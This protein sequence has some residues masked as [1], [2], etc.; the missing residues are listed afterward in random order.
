MTEYYLEA[1]VMLSGWALIEADS[2]D[3][4]RRKF[5]K[6]PVNEFNEYGERV[7]RIEGGENIE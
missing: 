1:E 4:A 5:E 7:V 2:W 6:D 3:E